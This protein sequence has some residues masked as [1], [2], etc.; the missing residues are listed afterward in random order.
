MA[1]L[2]QKIR[3]AR[4]EKSLSQKQLAEELGVKQATV[5]N[6]EL[7]KAQ[8][9][10]DNIER[11][12]EILDLPLRIGA[13]ITRKRDEM[14]MTVS[15]LAEQSGVS[16]PAIYKL[17]KGEI[18]NPRDVTIEKLEKVLNK[19]PVEV[20]EVSDEASRIEGLGSIQDFSP[21]EEE[22]LPTT[23]GVYLLYDVSQRPIYIG[24]SKNI[25]RRLKQHFEKF[26]F[27]SPIVEYASYIE[28]QDD[29]LR[30]QV[31]D[32]LIKSLKSNA[33]IN[34]KGVDSFRD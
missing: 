29:K 17:E 30:K 26:W 7:G 14:N 31:E 10:G 18:E 21:H 13:W 9:T 12:E 15:E 1:G 4:Q 34:Y 24:E 19:V 22:E 6:W 25:K 8:P 33:V 27:R 28:I 23:S 32:V 5:S 20:K 2:G 3:E 16:I 11:I